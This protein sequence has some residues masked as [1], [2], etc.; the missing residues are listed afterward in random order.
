MRITTGGNVGIGT[1]NPG[2][3]LDIVKTTAGYV[4]GRFQNNDQ[5]ANSFAMLNVN[6]YGNSWG[7]RMGTIAANSNRL[8]FVEDANGARTP[9]LSI[10]VGGNVG[11]GTTSPDASMG[12]GLHIASA[13]GNSLILQ[14]A[15]G[16][17]MQFR[18]DASTIRATISGINGADG[19]YFATGAA[20]TERATITSTGL[21]VT[22]TSGADGS[23]YSGNVNFA[24]SSGTTDGSYITNA[25]KLVA[26]ANGDDSLRL[27][28]RSSDGST[29]LF[30]RDTTNIGNISVTTVATTFNSLSDYR[31][32][33]NVQDLT[34]SG[35]FIDALKPRTFDWDSGDKGVGFIAH[36]FAEV[37]PSSVAG[38]KDAIDSDGKPLYQTMQASSAEVI[39]N[40][41]A[42]LQSLRARVAALE[43]N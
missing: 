11:I 18:S 19:L 14:K 4:I 28:R 12:P 21:A 9:R 35:E 41:V 39:A 2:A 37:S 34:G 29:A 8:D 24:V 40:L 16:A 13:S 36:E 31:R 17:A 27:R 25:G 42:E 43:T 1:T 33:S 30:Y 38:E 3:D 5:G 15:T 10:A 26:S 23:V 20:Q 6:A 32:K 7:M 22:G